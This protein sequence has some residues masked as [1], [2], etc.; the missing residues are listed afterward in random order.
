MHSYYRVDLQ[1]NKKTKY[2]EKFI[3]NKIGG[4]NIIGSKFKYHYEEQK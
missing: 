1:N 4:S 2:Y 3:K